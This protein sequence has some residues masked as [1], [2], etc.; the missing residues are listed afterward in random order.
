MYHSRSQVLAAITAAAVATG[1]CLAIGVGG[2]TE[3]TP[4]SLLPASTSTAEPAA[5]AVPRSLVVAETTVLTTALISE[6]STSTVALTPTSE[7]TASTPPAS[8]PVATLPPVT[9]T[10]VGPS[11]TSAPPPDTSVVEADPPVPETIA[12]STTTPPPPV[13]SGKSCPQWE[14]TARQVGWP[15]EAIP[16]LS[17]IMWRESRCD[18]T[19]HNPRPPDDSYCLIQLNM[20]AHRSWVGPQVDGDFTRLYEPSTCLSLGLQLWNT[21]GWRPWR[22]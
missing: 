2:S 19:A 14:D 20:R 1:F 4:A 21:A 10:S 17:Y 13:A 6:S 22:T 12:T 7:V 11:T 8:V 16:R 3:A 5:T 18:P 9:E 15:E